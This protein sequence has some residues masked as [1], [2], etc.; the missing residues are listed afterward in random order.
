MTV[1]GLGSI[2]NRVIPGADPALLPRARIRATRD[3]NRTWR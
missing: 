3:R 1:E 2:S